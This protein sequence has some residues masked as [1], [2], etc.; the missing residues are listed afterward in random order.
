MRRIPATFSSTQIISNTNWYGC[1]CLQNPPI[2]LLLGA[3]NLANCQGML[4]SPWFLLSCG[5]ILWGPQWKSDCSTHTF[6]QS[7][8]PELPGTLAQ[9]FLLTLPRSSSS[10]LY[11]WR[12]GAMF[13]CSKPQI[14]HHGMPSFRWTLNAWSGKSVSE[15]I[16]RLPTHYY[17]QGPVSLVPP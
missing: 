7:P 5:P 9:G 6:E 2:E 15:S 3:R 1:G 8:S 12:L 10:W 17:F 11:G 13:D 14:S 4:C 16:R